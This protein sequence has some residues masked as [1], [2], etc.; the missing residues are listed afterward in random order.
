[1]E[2]TGGKNKKKKIL[3][4]ADADVSIGIGDLMS[5]V[6]LSRYF[7]ADG[8]EPFF[9]YR[10]TPAA[11]RLAGKYIGGNRRVLE[12]SMSVPEE[13]AAINRCVEEHGIDMIF[14]EI[15]GRRLSEYSGLTPDAA[16]A[17]VSFDGDILPGMDLVVDWDVE[18]RRY[19]D[20]D[21]H[22]G[23]RFLLGPQYVIL[24]YDFD[25]DRI[26]KRRYRRPPE[27]LLVSMG[28]ADEFDLTRRVVEALAARKV[29]MKVTIVLGFGYIYGEELKKFLEYSGLDYE[30]KRDVADMF[31]EYM[32]CDVAVGAGGLT[33][34]ELVATRTPAVLIAAYEH[35][36][37]RC[38]FFEERGW[39]R[40]LGY[41]N[42]DETR[43]LEL[44]M[45]PPSPPRGVVFNT[46]KIVEAANEI[47]SET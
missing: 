9:M 4:R 24:P 37:A 19:F 3:F 17:C 2:K 23:T 25:Y 20:P 21:R 22:P 18:A 41:R 27:R 26:E 8:W 46:G 39:S 43:L 42:F 33:S 1:M 15:T 7:E 34:S 36:I 44:L 12:G 35:Q 45:N 29:E 40:Y 47:V 28:G 10:D 31:E 38:R 5:L 32:G 14:F 11:D 13:V 16:K 30:I 6:H